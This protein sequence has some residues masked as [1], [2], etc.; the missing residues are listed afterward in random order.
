MKVFLCETIHPE[1][2]RLLSEHAEINASRAGLVDEEALQEKRLG[3]A[4]LD[5]TWEE[6]LP[7]DSPLFA[8]KNV[9]CTPHY[10]PTTH[11]SAYNCAKIAA[12]NIVKYFAGEEVL[13]RI[14]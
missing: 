2:Y 11:D 8:M 7:K 9:I 14:V 10:A 3:G 6:P 4:G 13:G 1:A 12:E 5:V